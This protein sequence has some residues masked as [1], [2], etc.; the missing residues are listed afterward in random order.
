MFIRDID[1]YTVK[2]T[3]DPP[4]AKLLAQGLY[5][6]CE[7]GT[8]EERAAWHGM[9]S[10]LEVAGFAATLVNHPKRTDPD[11]DFTLQRYLDGKITV[12]AA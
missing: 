8:P 12:D 1:D 5:W 2:L 11:A 10:A 7:H 4:I 9:A 3:L 6:A